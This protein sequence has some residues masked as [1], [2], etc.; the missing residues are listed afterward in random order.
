MI[1]LV[2]GAKRQ[3][4]PE[5]DRPGDPAGRP[6]HRVPD[7]D[8]D[9]PSVRR[10]R[11]HDRRH[12]RPRR[13]ARL[14]DP[15][16]DRRPPVGDRDRRDGPGRP[17]QRPRDERPRGRGVGRRRRHPARQDRHDHLRQPARGVDHRRR[18]GV[19]RGRRGPRR[20]LVSSIQ[21]ETPGGSLHRR[22]SPASRLAELGRPAGTGDEAGFAALADRSPRTIP[23]RAETRT[24]GVRLADRRRW[25]SRAPWT[26]S[27]R[28]RRRAAGRASRPATDRIADLGRHAARPRAA[29]AAC[30]A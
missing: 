18:P 3:R 15:D 25:S 9:P 26:P 2:E 29:T 6:D 10:V 14:P 7:G 22:R 23:F 13:A 17:V 1:A 27:T 20:A 28:K 16:D 11:R 12:G 4:T 30:S 8:R 24:S 5:R 21:D 19:H